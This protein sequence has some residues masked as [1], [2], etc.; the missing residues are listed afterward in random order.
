MSRPA[1]LPRLNIVSPHRDDAAFTD[2]L[3]MLHWLREGGTVRII[4]VF[5]ESDFSHWNLKEWTPDA[6]TRAWLRLHGPRRDGVRAKIVGKARRLVV[7]RLR[8]RE[9]ERMMAALC[10]GEARASMLDLHWRDAC[11]RIPC[12]LKDILNP[13]MWNDDRVREAS[14]LS[15]QLRTLLAGEPVVAPLSVGGHIDHRVV[16][17]ACVKLRDVCPLAF[18]VDLPYATQADPA[19]IDAQRDTVSAELGVDLE[20][21]RVDAPSDAAGAATHRAMVSAYASQIVPA[22]VEQ[23]LSYLADGEVCWTTPAFR[24]LC[25]SEEASTAVTA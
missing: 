16:T 13:S 5:T 3:L 18:G 11:R 25:H 7:S 6:L 14:E 8:R 10:A 17:A 19:E 12:R 23:M 9:D 2:G 4:N 1:A 15:N 21:F 22:Q 24:A 20:S